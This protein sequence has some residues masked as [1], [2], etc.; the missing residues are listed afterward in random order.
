MVKNYESETKFAIVR[1]Y[2]E[3]MIAVS[4]QCNEG[5]RT[6]WWKNRSPRLK[7][8]KQHK[9]GKVLTSYPLRTSVWT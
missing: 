3:K 5:S 2:A 9:V 7:K 8:A 4:V 1:K 6:V